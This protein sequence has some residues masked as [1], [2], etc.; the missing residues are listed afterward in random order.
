[1]SK[2]EYENID[3]RRTALLGILRLF[4]GDKVDEINWSE[5][6]TSE[7]VSEL[8]DYVDSIFN[9]TIDDRLEKWYKEA[10]MNHD[11]HPH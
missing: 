7:L 6:C 8:K 2:S 4:G 9:A 10:D 5:A 11:V 1:M 3:D